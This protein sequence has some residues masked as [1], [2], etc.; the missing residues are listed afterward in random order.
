MFTKEK[1]LN[2][3]NVNVISIILVNAVLQYRNYI[4]AYVGREDVYNILVI[5]IKKM[6]LNVI[7][8]IIS[9]FVKF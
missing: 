1:H 5:V 2:F 8:K 4:Y 7:Q 6:L 3:Q 9:V